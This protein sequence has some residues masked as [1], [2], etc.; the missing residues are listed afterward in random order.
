MFWLYETTELAVVYMPGL[1]VA[2][3]QNHRATAKIEEKN[4][5][6]ACLNVTMQTQF[7]EEND[8]SIYIWQGEGRGYVSMVSQKISVGYNEGRVRAT[9][10]AVFLWI[11]R[12]QC[13]SSTFSL[14]KCK[15]K[16]A[17]EHLKSRLISS[18][19]RKIN[20][21]KVSRRRSWSYDLPRKPIK[22][23]VSDWLIGISWQSGQ[24]ELCVF[25]K[26]VW[27]CDGDQVSVAMLLWKV[28]RHPDSHLSCWGETGEE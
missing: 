4:K 27:L 26:V 17:D 9:L 3:K 15:I 5:A 14:S 25:G 18:H 23:W 6:H 8:V 19:S 20:Q 13:L 7:K 28:G 12:G 10:A 2:T 1:E 22:L 16:K 11:F 24:G 21:S